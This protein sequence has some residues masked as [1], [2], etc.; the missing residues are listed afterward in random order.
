MQKTLLFLLLALSFTTFSQSYNLQSGI[1]NYR[2]DKYDEAFAFLKKEIAQNPKEGKAYYYL[3]LINLRNET[4]AQGLTQVNLAIANLNPSDSLVASAWQVKGDIYSRLED[5]EK[6]EASYARALALNPNSIPINYGRAFGYGIATIANDGAV[7]DTYFHHL[8]L[9]TSPS[10]AAPDLSRF[11][12][13]DEIRKVSKN[14]F[15]SR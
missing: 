14:Q 2:E 9:G 1:N 15:L 5:L 7:L 10:S 6:F 11:E 3:A 12:G 4:Y 13:T 8:G